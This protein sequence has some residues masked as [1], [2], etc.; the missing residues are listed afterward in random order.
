MSK[1]THFTVGQ[2][3]IWISRRSKSGEA[4]FQVPGHVIKRT[5]KRIT[6]LV[7]NDDLSPCLR[8]VSPKHLI[9]GTHPALPPSQLGQ[10]FTHR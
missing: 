10:S 3:I 9:P 4:L 5:P 8:H 1:R 2:A 7:R 6:I